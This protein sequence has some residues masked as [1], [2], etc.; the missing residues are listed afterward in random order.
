MP[1][2][3]VC[4]RGEWKENEEEYVGGQLKGLIVNIRIMYEDL[5]WEIYRIGGINFIEIDLV[6]R[7]L[8]NVRL[9][10]STFVISNQEDL[11]FF[12]TGDDVSQMTLLVSKLLVVFHKS[13]ST[14]LS[15]PIQMA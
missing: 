14:I 3:F 1:R 11:N 13:R 12:L 8:Y 9:N 6:I 10:V 5:L 7:C 2:I 15:F 4:F